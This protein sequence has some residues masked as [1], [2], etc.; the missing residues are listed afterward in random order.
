MK[1]GILA[2]RYAKAL[3]QIA[4]ERDLVEEV[5]RELYVL[6]TTLEENRRLALRILSPQYSRSDKRRTVTQVFRQRFST[7]F[8]NFLQ[9]L[10]D[11]GRAGLYQMIYRAFGVLY[12][13]HQQRLRAR[14]TS[15]IPLSDSDKRTLQ[16][17]LAARLQKNLEIENQVDSSILGGLI[18]NVEGKV[19]DGS[20]KR[21]LERLREVMSSQLN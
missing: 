13:Q 6:V 9:L 11:K 20:V 10:I 8:F 19:L 14:V 17:E 16:Q 7:L 21:Q 5:R 1:E 2:R 15:A 3:F 18:V 4:L 12:D